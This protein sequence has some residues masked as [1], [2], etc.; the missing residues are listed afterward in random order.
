MNMAVKKIVPKYLLASSSHRAVSKS[1]SCTAL[2]W[3]SSGWGRCN[4]F[5]S[6]S[7]PSGYRTT[8]PVQVS[9]TSDKN[10]LR[11]KMWAGFVTT[12]TFALNPLNIHVQDDLSE[13]HCCRACCL[14]LVMDRKIL[15]FWF[16]CF[17]GSWSIELLTKLSVLCNTAK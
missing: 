12:W 6:E 11:G 7:V 17:P 16:L 4:A 8:Q 3:G 9:V 5:F 2:L 13:K 1:C 10:S 14:L 15:S